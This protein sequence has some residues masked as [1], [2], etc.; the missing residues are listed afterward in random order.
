MKKEIKTLFITGARGFLGAYLLK[1]FNSKYKVLGS[2]RKTKKSENMFKLD[3]CCPADFDVSMFAGVDVLVHCAG[4]AHGKT[5]DC[6]YYEINTEGTRRVVSAALSGGVGHII[7]ISSL[8]VYNTN[9]ASVTINF[10]TPAYP[11]SD[12]GK[13][14]LQAENIAHELCDSAEVPLTIIRPSLIFASEAPGNVA[15]L[16]KAIEKR[17]PILVSRVANSRALITLDGIAEII[18]DAINEPPDMT[19][20]VLAS[21]ITMSIEDMV[22][23]L[24]DALGLRPRIIR[25]FQGI[26]RF[27]FKLP[28][29]RSTAFK[30]YG[31]LIIDNTPPKA[32]T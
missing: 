5:A 19:S 12:Y 28:F 29:I 3:L 4:L 32:D 13:S 9:H 7:F 14:K 22:L 24:S 17:V 10:E 23:S 25:A 26:I 21:N 18:D 6:D 1:Y 30:L 16:R 8:A 2:D 11:K 15:L 27:G 20:V 31:D